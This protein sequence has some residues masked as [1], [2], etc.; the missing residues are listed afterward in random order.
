MEENIQL[1]TEEGEILKEQNKSK[2]RETE[3][4]ELLIKELENH[5]TSS[6]LKNE[7]KEIDDDIVQ[8]KEEWEIYEETEVKNLEHLKDEVMF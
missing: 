1:K 3:K 2:K 4:T 8:I 6:D 5:G 7:I